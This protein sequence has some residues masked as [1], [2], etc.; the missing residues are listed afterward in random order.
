MGEFCLRC[1]LCMLPFPAR[2]SLLQQGRAGAG[3]AVAGCMYRSKVMLLVQP[4]VA[5]QQCK[6]HMFTARRC[7]E[8][9][10]LLP[11]S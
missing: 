5:S 1:L 4:V 8:V 10:L 3:Q 11:A 6:E 2:L 9:L 7:F